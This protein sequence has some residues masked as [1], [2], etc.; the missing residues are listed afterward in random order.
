[1]VAN[2]RFGHV[3][4]PGH[5]RREHVHL[6]AEPAAA[7]RR[8]QIPE[9]VE[10][11]PAVA[12]LAEIMQPVDDGAVVRQTLANGRARNPGFVLTNGGDG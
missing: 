4:D 10:D 6:L 9:E 5:L 3:D 2:C 1:M 12:I 11:M 7:R 8:L